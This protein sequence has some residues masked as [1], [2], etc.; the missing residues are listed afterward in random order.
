MQKGSDFFVFITISFENVE[1]LPYFF[2]DKSNFLWLILVDFVL[3]TPF[4]STVYKIQQSYGLCVKRGHFSPVLILF[5][6]IIIPS[7]KI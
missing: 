1:V 2:G 4:L 5:L 7:S 3:L 6:Y